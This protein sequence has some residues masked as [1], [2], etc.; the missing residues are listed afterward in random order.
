MTS[1]LSAVLT[2]K[3]WVDNTKK[4]DQAVTNLS[5]TINLVHLTLSPLEDPTVSQCLQPSVIASLLSIGE[6]LS[7]IKDHLSPWQDRRLRPGKLWGIVSPGGV[8]NDLCDDAQL[9]S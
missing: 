7:R 5:T 3:T 2:I 1:V 8:I 4:K 9:L 6:V